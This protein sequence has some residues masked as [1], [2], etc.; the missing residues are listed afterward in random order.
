MTSATI[1]EDSAFAIRRK[2]F[3]SHALVRVLLHQFARQPLGRSIRRAKTQP[4]RAQR[5]HCAAVRNCMRIL[6]D[7]EFRNEL[8]SGQRVAVSAC[9]MGAV[10]APCN[11]EKNS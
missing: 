6:T 9:R 11:G 3:I 4:K 2:E 5:I 7:Y 8:A 10:R 1:W